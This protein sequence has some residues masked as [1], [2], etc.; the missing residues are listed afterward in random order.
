MKRYLAVVSLEEALETLRTGFAFPHP[1]E[2]VPL[3]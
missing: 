3:E 2:T 1:C